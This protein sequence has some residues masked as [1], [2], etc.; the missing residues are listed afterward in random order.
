VRN[1]RVEVLEEGDR[2]VFLHQV[3]PGSADRSYGIHVARLAGVPRP[4][5]Q[6]AE[7]V[8]AKLEVSRHPGPAEAGGSA[9][10]GQDGAATGP[11]GI[12]ASDAGDGLEAGMAGRAS[13]N[14][15][16]RRSGRSGGL[17]SAAPPAGMLQL[18]LFAPS[19]PLVDELKRLD[20]MNLT[21]LDALNRLADLVER[22]RRA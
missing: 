18:S 11:S 17:R 10:A 12:G 20:V 13:P 14:G 9:D 4:V 7:A 19:H 8:L 16:T 21:P 2:V 5:T 15:H 6:R 1:Y 22:A 3:V